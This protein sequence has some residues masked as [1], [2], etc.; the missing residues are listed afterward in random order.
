MLVFSVCW[1]AVQSFHFIFKSDGLEPA[2]CVWISGP[3][4]AKFSLLALSVLEEASAIWRQ[5]RA[6]QTRLFVSI[7]FV[8]PLQ[9]FSDVF[10]IRQSSQKR[11]IFTQ[12]WA[13]AKTRI[14]ATKSLT[15]V[16]LF[17]S[18][19]ASLYAELERVSI[20]QNVGVPYVLIHKIIIPWN[21]QFT[22]KG[23]YSHNQNGDTCRSYDLPER[24][25][26]LPVTGS[27]S[28]HHV[29]LITP[30]E[31]RTLG[32]RKLFRDRIKNFRG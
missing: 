29:C 26:R 4:P 3:K 31:K 20:R 30:F 5:S 6:K 23:N 1:F 2:V 24:I 9:Y 19:L 12:T 18:P 14:G 25:L 15:L 32:S 17:R 8:A 16:S 7:C 22:S 11:E 28:R 27:G 10:K 21:S 13:K